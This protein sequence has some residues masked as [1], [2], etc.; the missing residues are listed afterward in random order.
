MT[1]IATCA[2][3]PRPSNSVMRATPSRARSTPNRTTKSATAARASH[4]TSTR[5][6]PAVGSRANAPP[7]ARRHP[8]R[9][10]HPHA[11]PGTGIRRG[12]LVRS[13]AH[14]RLGQARTFPRHPCPLPRPHPPPPQ[15]VDHTRGL[16]G[17]HV[18]VHHLNDT[19]KVLAYLRWSF[20][21]PRDQTIV[22]ANFANA[23]TTRTESA[24]PAPEGGACDSTAT[25][26]AT[27]PTSATLRAS[28]PT[29]TPS[30]STE[31]HTAPPLP[32]APTPSLSSRRTTSAAEKNSTSPHPVNKIRA[33]RLSGGSRDGCPARPRLFGR[34]SSVGRAADS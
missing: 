5:K 10:R 12:R 33:P 4:R 27:A 11:L 3:W 8:H 26:K 22:L 24:S 17:D 34:C 9:T 21:E 13:R 30:R 18:R 28:T 20:A 16:R 2:K 14:A 25:G 32:S 15:L 19:A 29:P 31:C 7:W 23:L 1:R 6:T